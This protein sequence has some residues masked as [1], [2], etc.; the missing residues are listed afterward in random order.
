MPAEDL[1]NKFETIALRNEKL[2]LLPEKAI[3]WPSKKL[4]LIADLHIGKSAHFRK[5]GIA[6][7]AIA[8]NNNWLVLHR[9][10]KLHEPERVCFLGDLFHSTKNKVWEVFSELINSYPQIQF[11]LVIGNHDILPIKNYQD[12]GFKVLESLLEEPFLFTHEPLEDKS[13]YY[14]LAGHLHPGVKL[15]GKGKQTHRLPCFYFEKNGGILPAFGAFTGL[16]TL[17]IKK[18]VQVFAIV[19][20]QVMKL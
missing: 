4:L 5:N 12:I 10:F 17:S 18:D 2:F 7:P 16:S 20:D 13:S 8:E 19:E 11:E 9:L 1:L 14:N 3:Y 6:V 15:R